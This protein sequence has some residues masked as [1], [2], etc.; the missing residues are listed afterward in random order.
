MVLTQQSY[1]RGTVGE[2]VSQPHKGPNAALWADVW[3]GSRCPF[4]S[5]STCMCYA[6]GHLWILGNAHEGDR[7]WKKL[8]IID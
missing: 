7:R 2:C 1:Q 3:E 4:P 5:I 8:H 6:K